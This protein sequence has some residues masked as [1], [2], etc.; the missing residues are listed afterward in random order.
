[1]HWKRIEQRILQSKWLSDPILWLLLLWG[2]FILYGTLLPFNF[3]VPLELVEQRLQR[4]WA[5][6][7]K[8]GSWTDVYGNVLLF[9]P[10]GLLLAIV[11][12]RR[13]AGFFVAV[14]V[15]MCTGAFLSGSVELAQLFVPI[16]NCSFVDVVTNA[17]GATV[18][19]IIGWPLFRLVWPILSVRLR[20][21]IISHPL[22][23]CAF[24]TA[25]VLLLSGLSPFGFKPSPHDLKAA[26]A[27]VQW[28]PFGPPAAES[29]RPTKPLYWAA[30]LLTWTL[31]GGLFALAARESR[32]RAAGAIGWAV[33]VSLLLSLA[34]EASQ[35]AIPTRDVDATSI[36]LAL[37]GSASGA[38]VVVLSRER[39]PRRLIMPAIVIWS[40]AVIFTLWNPPRFTPREPP[41]W[42]LA[43]VVP[44]WSYFFS[45]TLADLAD[46]IGQVLIFMPL[47]ALLAARTNRQSF[48]GALLIGLS[49][50]AVREVGQAFLP[51]R[52][53]DISDAL[54]AAAGTA[55][56]LVLWRWGEWTR[57][58]STGAIR[59]RIPRPR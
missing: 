20:H 6:P 51:G 55:A 59:Y 9:V 3:T 19:A 24:L 40:L 28:V 22:A 14:A 18:G 45:R 5:R 25:G 23:I 57:A 54:S 56:G 39:D 15:A 30:E 44:F 31:A 32:F 12:A 2:L 16:R 53:P 58:S 46:V 11:L 1:M 47:G 27:A 52:S 8:G 37:F 7:L 49:F 29:L 21:A 38:A 10:W 17:F 42:N 34:I 33:G 13:G 26:F 4:I 41:Y 35:L 36:V 50:S 48:V 43:M